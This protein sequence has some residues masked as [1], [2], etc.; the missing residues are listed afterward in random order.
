MFDIMI[1]NNIHIDFFAVCI[2]HSE[3]DKFFIFIDLCA[4]VNIGE[5]HFFGSKMAFRYGGSF[6]QKGKGFYI[7]GAVKTLTKYFVASIILKK[8]LHQPQAL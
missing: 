6:C 2:G 1:F 8:M 4:F 7:L 5:I 3:D